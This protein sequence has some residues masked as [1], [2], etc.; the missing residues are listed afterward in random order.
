MFNNAGAI[1][2]DPQKATPSPKNTSYN[3][4]LNVLPNPQSRMLYSAFQP[5]QYH[6][7]WGIYT[8]CNTCSLVLD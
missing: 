4:Q 3:A 7:L 8:P 5:Q 1:I 6:L 2:I